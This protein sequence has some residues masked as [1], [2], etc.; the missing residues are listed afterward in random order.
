[1]RKMIAISLFMLSMCFAYLSGGAQEEC[2]AKYQTQSVS[3]SSAAD[4]YGEDL[5][6]LRECGCDMLRSASSRTLFSLEEST[7]SLT[8][9][10]LRQRNSS[11]SETLPHVE[12][13]RHLG[14]VNHI[15]DY[16]KLR[17]SL[18]KI[19]YL[20]ALCRLRI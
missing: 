15:F 7:V 18:R 9:N 14:H 5:A 3:I 19:Y 11:V 6:M 16:D 20:H 12:P 4:S 17:S 10:H 1:M 8:S 2:V 13:C